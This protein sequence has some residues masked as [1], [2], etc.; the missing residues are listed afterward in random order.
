MLRLPMCPL[1]GGQF[2]LTIALSYFTELEPK[3]DLHGSEH[4]VDL[5]ACQLDALWTW[6]C[7][8]F[9]PLSSRVPPSVARSPPD[10]TGEE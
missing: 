6:T 1:G 3:L 9:K 7:R 4:N 5:I 10:D 2:V 8:A